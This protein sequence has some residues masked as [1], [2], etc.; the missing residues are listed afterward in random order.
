MRDK[1]GNYVIQRVLDISSE[2][3]RN[4][5]IEKILKAA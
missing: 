5:F 2:Q 4:L 1:Y 3:Q